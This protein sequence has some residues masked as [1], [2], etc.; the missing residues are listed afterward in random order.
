MQNT[1]ALAHRM[2]RRTRK[3]SVGANAIDIAEINKGLQS[4]ASYIAE[5]SGELAVMA[6]GARFANLAQLLAKAQLEGELCS[7]HCK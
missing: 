7:R 2:G 6:G 4:T 5:L 3:A 1:A